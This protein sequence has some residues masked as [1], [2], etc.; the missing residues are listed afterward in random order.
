MLG[1][2]DPFEGPYTN[3][4]MQL[5]DMDGA[6][7]ARNLGKKTNNFEVMLRKDLNNRAREYCP[8]H[9]SK[10]NVYTQRLLDDNTEQQR[11]I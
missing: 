8:G 9:N 6:E 1:L 7:L 4:G 3:I 11:Q 10:T 2:K 5:P